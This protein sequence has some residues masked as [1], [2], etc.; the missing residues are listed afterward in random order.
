MK[1]GSFDD[2]LLRC[3]IESP[4]YYVIR[5]DLEGR[6]TYVNPHF[7]QKF[8]YMAANFHGMPFQETIH[9]GDVETCNQAAIQCI[10]RPGQP[11]KLAIRKSGPTGTF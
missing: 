11:V 3:L 9:P 4:T 2:Q 8:S 10:A 1:D 7:Q 6:Y 5:T